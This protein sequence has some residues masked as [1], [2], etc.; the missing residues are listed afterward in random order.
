VKALVFGANGQDGH[1]LAE[2]LQSRAVE[3][4]GFSRSGD[5]PRADVS[6]A[7]EVESAIARLQPDLVFHLAAR[8][9]TRHEALF[10]NHETIS[11]GTLNVL[12]SVQK[13]CPAARVFIAGSGVQFK[14]T[15]SPIDEETPFEASSAYAV[16][17]IQSVYAARYY[18]SRGLRTYVG[19]LFH[20]ESPRRGPTHLSRLIALAAQQIG[21]GRRAAPIE[22]GDPSVV[23]EWTFAGDTVHAILTLVDQQSVFEA[24]IGTGEGHSVEDWLERCFSA[25]GRSWRD[26]V[27][28]TPGFRPEYQSLLSR[29]TRIMSLGWRPQVRFEELATMMVRARA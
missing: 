13:H 8:S 4:V 9:T 18:R 26:H 11:T 29:P 21:D 3:V 19:Y 12:E 14:N 25:V 20:H 16:A 7:A 28:I 15:G 24:V 5:W 27:V 1:Y 17:R 23:K 2:A 22:I 10:E 6:K